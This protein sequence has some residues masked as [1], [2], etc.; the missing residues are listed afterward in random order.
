MIEPTEREKFEIQNAQYEFPYHYI[1]HING[2]GVPSLSRRLVWGFDY[3]CYQKHLYERVMALRPS[4]VLEVGCG[5]GYFIGSLPQSIPVRVGVDLSQRAIAFAKAFHPDCRF[6]AKDVNELDEKFDVVAAIE[7]LEH[8]PEDVLPEF[9]R[10]LA[11]KTAKDGIVVISVPTVVLPLNKKHYRHYTLSLLIDQLQK[12]NCGLR[13]VKH[14]Y[15]YSEPWWFKIFSKMFDNRIFSLEV[16]PFMARA[17]KSIWRK[18]RIAEE[19][20]GFHLVAYLKAD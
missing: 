17:W 8:I 13:I 7:V 4:S 16:K 6:Y 20:N 12:S 5:D 18:Y 3:L 1:P 11:S 15:V 2:R 19:R 10:S 9:L 14:E